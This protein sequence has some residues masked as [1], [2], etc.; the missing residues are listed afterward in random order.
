M[1]LLS[2]L[3]GKSIRSSNQK[4]QLQIKPLTSSSSSSNP[5]KKSVELRTKK[6]KRVYPI[7]K[8][9]IYES[10]F[11]LFSERKV[12]ILFRHQ[13]LK[14][15]QWNSIRSQLKSLSLNSTEIDPRPDQLDNKVEIQF[16]RT[17]MISP[18]LKEII[19]HRKSSDT[20]TS[21]SST[22]DFFYKLLD[23]NSQ[24][25]KGNLTSLTSS[26]F[27]PSIISGALKIIS[28]HSIDKSKKNSNDRSKEES[29]RLPF[30][31]GIIDQKEIFDERVRLEKRL[32]EFKGLKDPLNEMRNQI[33][34][35]L[36]GLFNGL[37]KTLENGS[38]KRLINTLNGFKND[39]EK[40]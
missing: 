27:N 30:L 13:D 40:S 33:L 9:Y 36:F 6:L 2:L 16:L 26:D 23:C 1:V 7:R 17:R 5:D 12:I 34:G 10:Y 19:K 8:Q 24:H 39:L 18:V 35:S 25:L 29:E 38:G 31:I 14:T 32:N 11:D 37:T 3:R 20:H 22:V 28:N 21:S 15:N 4:Q